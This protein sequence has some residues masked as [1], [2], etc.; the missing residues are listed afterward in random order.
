MTKEKFDNYRFGIKTQ[1]TFEGKDWFDIISV[2]FIDGL[3]EF[4]N[5]SYNY[6]DI[7]DLRN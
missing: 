1:A 6:K 5:G 3:I 2:D 4:D 7:L